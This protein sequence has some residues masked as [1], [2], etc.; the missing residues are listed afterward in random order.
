MEK[1]SWADRVRKEEV[2]Q[3]FK[4]ERKI[5]HTTKR[6]NTNWIGQI[7]HRNCLIK[8]VI[9]GKM[10]GTVRGG[11]R[12]KQLPDDFKETRRYYVTIPN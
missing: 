4:E 8:H 11:M 2:L 6:W 5:L 9:E 10:K 12:R 7:L 3:T 1:I